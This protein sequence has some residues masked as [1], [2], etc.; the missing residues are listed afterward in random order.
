MSEITK[1][2]AQLKLEETFKDLSEN[3]TKTDNKVEQIQKEFEQKIDTFN[4]AVNSDINFPVK[5]SSYIMKVFSSIHQSLKKDSK[6]S[7]CL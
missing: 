1:N 3:F 4:E 2:N 6:T 7:S 5:D